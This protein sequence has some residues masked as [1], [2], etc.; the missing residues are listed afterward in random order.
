MRVSAIFSGLASLML[1]ACVVDDDAT[2]DSVT[3]SDLT[4]PDRIWVPNAF[5]ASATLSAENGVDTDSAFF[6]DLGTNGRTCG[7]CHSLAT[8]WSVTP[9]QLQLRFALSQGHDAIFRLN[10][11]ATSPRAAV[12]T[13]EDRRTA[14]R[15]LLDRGTIRVGMPMPANAEFE[16]VTVDDPYGYASA[17]ELSLFRRPLPAANLRFNAVVMWDGRETPA[18]GATLHDALAHQANGATMGHA[19]GIAVEPG[20]LDEIVGFE[21]ALTNAQVVSFTAGRLDGAAGRGGLT[22]LAEQPVVQGPMTL[23]DAWT[24]QPVASD[25]A[26]IARGQVVFNTALD[27]AGGT[28]SGCHNVANVGTRFDGRLFNARVSKPELRKP[29]QPLYTFRRISTGELR[30]TTDPGRA[31]VT[32][33]WADMDRFKVPGLRALAA[34]PPYFHDGSAGTIEAVVRHYEAQLGFVLSDGQRTDLVAFLAAL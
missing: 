34:R 26:A 16:L 8:G 30:S 2:T 5:G 7:D 12:A 33:L 20:L 25:R 32:G 15:M 27:S 10:D 21:V 6:A 18:A 31:L 22:A 19:Q 1:A 28:C 17:A 14:Y 4:V 11:G 13:F 9:L 29:E 23:F 3:E 24:T